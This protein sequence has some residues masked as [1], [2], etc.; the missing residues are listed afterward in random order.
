VN[1]GGAVARLGH[2]AQGRATAVHRRAYLLKPQSRG[3]YGGESSEWCPAHGVMI[4]YPKRYLQAR[5][6]N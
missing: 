5:C 4:F 1:H 6:T 3:K 2:A